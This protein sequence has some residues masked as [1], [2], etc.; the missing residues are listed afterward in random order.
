MRE[1]LRDMGREG[2]GDV[3]VD[4]E[5]HRLV[6][7]KER[8]RSPALSVCGSRLGFSAAAASQCKSSATST[9][10]VRFSTYETSSLEREHD[11]AANHVRCPDCSGLS[12]G[13]CMKKML[14]SLITAATTGT[15]E[16]GERSAQRLK[17]EKRVT[18]RGRGVIAVLPGGSRAAAGGQGRAKRARDTL[19]QRLL[20]LHPH[21]L[22][23]PP[24]CSCNTVLSCR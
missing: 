2:A 11:Y 6:S 9:L 5:P 7:G 12:I 16:D 24:L 17:M 4:R 14:H 1:L 13:P 21:S 8:R 19:M 3:V 10:V 15:I 23:L 20:L 18:R 22:L